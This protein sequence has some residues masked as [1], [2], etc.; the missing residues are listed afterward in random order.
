LI[1]DYFDGKSQWKVG[2]IFKVVSPITDQGIQLQDSTGH[3]AAWSAD[4]KPVFK[5]V[6]KKPKKRTT[7][8]KKTDAV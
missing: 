3:V 4:W 7:K 2:D 1:V 5:K 8:Q 6:R